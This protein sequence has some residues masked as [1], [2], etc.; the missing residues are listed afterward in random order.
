MAEREIRRK[1]IKVETVD[2]QNNFVKELKKELLTKSKI[3]K[4]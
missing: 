1:Q 2:K 4:R 3:L